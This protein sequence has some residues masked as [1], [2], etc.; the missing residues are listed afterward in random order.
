L[1]FLQIFLSFQLFSVKHP[2][3]LG[4]EFE[5]MRSCQLLVWKVDHSDALLSGFPKSSDWRFFSPWLLASWARSRSS[6]NPAFCTAFSQL[7]DFSGSTGFGTRRI[8]WVT[9]RLIS[10]FILFWILEPFLSVVF[11]Y[12]VY[13]CPVETSRGSILLL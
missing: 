2:D 12:S 8:F 3:G 1:L 7:L 10:I 4:L 9:C 6:T 5:R 11:I 13:P